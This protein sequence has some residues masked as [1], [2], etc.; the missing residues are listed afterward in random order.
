MECFIYEWTD[1]DENDEENPKFIIRGYGIT[2]KGEDVVVRID[3]FTPYLYMELPISIQWENMWRKVTDRIEE[4]L[5]KIHCPL[6]L[7]YALLHKKKLYYADE[8]TFPFVF[9]VFPTKESRLMAARFLVKQD[10]YR[11]YGKPIKIR[12]H[13]HE[14]SPL[15][16]FMCFRDL[17]STGWVN[18]P[19]AKCVKSSDT[20]C[21]YEV[22]TSFKKIEKNDC[23]S[24][25]PPTRIISF[26]L[27]VYSSNKNKMPSADNPE[28]VIFQ[29]CC[30]YQYKDVRENILLTLGQVDLGNDGSTVYTFRSEKELLLGFSRIILQKNPHVIIGYNIFGF[31][32]PY[33]IDRSHFHHI[34]LPWGSLGKRK[35]VQSKEK[36]ISWS[37]SAY[38]NQ[39]FRFME[40]E[41]RIVIDLLP[42]VRRDYKL[43]NYK[44]G[45]V[46]NFFLGSTK[47]PVSPRDIFEFFERYQQKQDELGIKLLSCIGKY[48]I[49]DGVLVLDLFHKLQLWIGLVEMAKLCNVPIPFLYTQGQ[50]IKVYSQIYKLCLYKKIVVESSLYHKNQVSH[51]QG[52]YVFDPV[53][54]IYDNIIPFDFSS[55]YPST[56]IAYNIDY[57]TLVMDPN[58]SDSKCHIITWTEEGDVVY[59]FRFLKEPKGILPTL[60]EDLLSQR[61]KTRTEM[62]SLDKESLLYTVLDKRQLAYKVSANSGYGFMGVTKGY[63]PFLPGAM[64]TTAM[65]RQSIQKAAEYVKYTYKGKLIYGDSVANYTPVYIRNNGIFDI[66]TIEDLAVQYGSNIWKKCTENDKEYCELTNH[67]ETWTD[68]GWTRLFRIIRHVLQPHKKMIRVLTHTGLV[69]VTDDH[70]LLLPNGEEISPKN[71][72]IGTSLLHYPF[73]SNEKE[74]VSISKEEARIMGF[75]FGDGSC[76]KYMCPSGQKASWALNNANMEMLEKYKQLCVIVYPQLNWVIMDTITSSGVYKLFPRGSVLPFVVKYRSQLYYNKSK[77]IPK[78]ILNGNDK[79]RQAFF[80]G[81]YDADGCKNNINTLID[82]KNQISASHIT[83]LASSLGWKTSLNSRNDKNNIYCITMTKSKQRKDPNKIKKLYEIDYKGYVYDLTTEN[84]HFAAGIG[85]LIVHNTDS[86]YCSFPEIQTN[87]LWKFALSVEKEFMA[88]F[89][90]PMK[91]VFEEKVYTRFLIFTKKRYLAITQNANMSIDKELTIRGILL[92]RRDNCLWIRKLYEEVVRKVMSVDTPRVTWEEMEYFMLTEFNKLCSHYWDASYITIC[93][94]VGKDYKI[95]PCPGYNEATQ[96]ITDESKWQKRMKELKICPQSKDWFRQYRIKVL[97][98]HGQLAIKMRNRGIPVEAGTRLEYLLLQHEDLKAKTFLKIEDPMYQKMFSDVLKIDYL[99]VLHLAANPFD[100]L[101]QI[102][103]GKPDFVLSQY[104][105]RIKKHKLLLELHAIF[106]PS[107]CFIV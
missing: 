103:F 4:G 26:D 81:L 94:A 13:E 25:P 64:S 47:D 17:P 29:I 8:R 39:E 2:E 50:Q 49:Q 104:E 3:D 51:F 102:C 44:L 60:L 1:I 68:K 33:M 55:L 35:N 78:E 31:D 95:R 56:I 45:T 6:P 100:Q 53:P 28:D 5:R 59:R 32:I 72:G 88:L 74:M 12:V 62:K 11:I 93:K 57:T 91:L 21:D 90:P 84:N 16:Q 27:E 7:K 83:Y 80:E 105:I 75:F 101:F 73:P 58:I 15:L 89:P 41:G 82:Q 52:A 37:S 77:I 70:S 61:K 107:L 65:G 18:I 43:R 54:G 14:A 30:I 23:K 48:C 19:D 42:I 36:Q 86:I 71:V 24:A 22:Q 106:S 85:N 9:M 34:Y 97:P 79:I 10:T 38:Q 46:S 76:G 20:Y 92:A 66:C 40:W 98:A 99:Y 96:E 63:L 67:V 69:D 87:Q